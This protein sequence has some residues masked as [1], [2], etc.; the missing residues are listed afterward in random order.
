MSKPL[1]NNPG[2]NTPSVLNA[3][4]KDLNRT[5]LHG[6]RAKDDQGRYKPVAIL[7]GQ[8]EA[9]DRAT[10]KQPVSFNLDGKTLV[11]LR[12]HAAKVDA[13]WEGATEALKEGSGYFQL[14][15]DIL[16]K[17]LATQKTLSL[18]EP[19]NRTAED[20]LDLPDERSALRLPPAL[21]GEL[22]ASGDR[23]IS[24][25]QVK[26][27]D[28][29]VKK[30]R[31]RDLV[32]LLPA[33]WEPAMILRCATTPACAP[34]DK[35]P[36]LELRG[37]P[38]G[39][40]WFLDALELLPTDGLPGKDL[41]PDCALSLWLEEGTNGQL[42]RPKPERIGSWTLARRNLTRLARPG[43][44]TFMAAAED[45]AYPYWS[46]QSMPADTL[47]LLQM[48][49]ITNSGGY[50]L[51]MP[52]M[53]VALAKENMT[54]VILL[55]FGG[56]PESNPGSARRM[57]PSANAISYDN[58]SEQDGRK[59]NEPEVVRLEGNANLSLSCYGAGGC[60][61]FGFIRTLPDL[62]DGKDTLH[63]AAGFAA[64]I[65]MLE[66]GVND[67]SGR[68]IRCFVNKKEVEQCIPEAMTPLSP[69]GDLMSPLD[70][71]KVM[72]AAE[73]APPLNPVLNVNRFT[74][75]TLRA[76]GAKGPKAEMKYYFYRTNFR[77][78]S[79]DERGTLYRRLKGDN[80]LTVV[81]GFRD[82]FGN[83]IKRGSFHQEIALYYTDALIAPAEWP[84]IE[85][86]LTPL[87]PAGSRAKVCLSASYSAF[88]P[89]A[90]HEGDVDFL[91][92][93]ERLLNS[94]EDPFAQMLR[95][96]LSGPL[97]KLLC[98]TGDL[99]HGAAQEA[100]SRLALELNRILNEGLDD[101][102]LFKGDGP[103]VDD[104]TLRLKASATDGWSR[105]RLNRKHMEAGLGTAMRRI[106]STD[107]DQ[108][109]NQ[110]ERLR[111]IREQLIGTG[112]DDVEVRL[113]DASFSFSPLGKDLRTELIG[114][115]DEI[116]DAPQLPREASC[117]FHV[118]A[119]GGDSLS[120]SRFAPELEIKRNSKYLPT[121][122]SL[123]WTEDTD[124]N[125]RRRVRELISNAHSRV[126]LALSTVADATRKAPW[127][128]EFR[129]VASQFR[130]HLGVPWKAQVGILRNRLNEHELWFIPNGH[131]PSSPSA[132]VLITPKPLKN[133]LGNGNFPIPDF[134]KW[135]GG[136][137]DDAI[138]EDF[139]ISQQ[140]FTKIDYDVV[141]RRIM[142]SIEAALLPDRLTGPRKRHWGKV[143]AAKNAL[144]RHL[145]RPSHVVPVFQ[146]D[147]GRVDESNSTRMCRDLFLRDLR[148]FYRIDTLLQVPVTPPALEAGGLRNFHG[149]I[150]AEFAGSRRSSGSRP[151]IPSFSD[152]VLSYEDSATGSGSK[153]G[154]ITFSYDLPPGEE[155]RWRDWHVETLKAELT[156]VQ[157]GESSDGEFSRGQW[158]ELVD[159]KESPACTIDLMSK[160]PTR[161]MQIPAI[162]RRFPVEPI[163]K[164]AATM[165]L[166]AAI[167]ELDHS[168]L[169][170]WDWIVNLATE[171]DGENDQ[172]HFEIEYPPD[173][174]P[175]PPLPRK[176]EFL[177]NLLHCMLVLDAAADVLAGMASLLPDEHAKALLNAVALL[178][179]DMKSFLQR[180]NVSSRSSI[181]KDLFKLS[182]AVT[183]E[184]PG[185]G[186]KA[187]EH[188]FVETA[189]FGLV[190]PDESSSNFLPRP[191]EASDPLYR[192]LIVSSGTR[193][194]R[195][196]AIRLFPSRG[197][198][199]FRPSISIVRNADL[200]EQKL[201]NPSLIYVC[202][203]VVWKSDVEVRQVLLQVPVK[204]SPGS[205]LQDV[206]HD[207][208]EA[209][210]GNALTDPFAG[211]AL[212]L[213]LKHV[214]TLDDSTALNP[215]RLIAVDQIPRTTRELA[216]QIR[217]VYGRWLT[218]ASQDE[219]DPAAAENLIASIMNR[220]P[221]L[222]IGLQVCAASGVSSTDSNAASIGRVL[223]EIE[224]LEIPL[225]G[226][227][228]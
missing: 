4:A 200:V 172:I 84:G 118:D 218:S 122:L 31:R 168:L 94:A 37:I 177:Q 123:R 55:E 99:P 143:L 32:E 34:G 210:F 59:L 42:E 75:D 36:I 108:E 7:A 26:T 188:H 49:S 57:P 16:P 13:S 74:K 191:E 10:M 11:T 184:W 93:G 5:L 217:E 161:T 226:L 121:E 190:P 206:L 92:L 124:G 76:R 216:A 111:E 212:S 166:D 207:E 223:L 89:H 214:F 209:I 69:L 6:A 35:T 41:P 132:P 83:V 12:E 43:V 63:D 128:K 52:G 91:Q 95:E 179:G 145:A 100:A 147:A 170:K 114:F 44:E 148:N 163:L 51:A 153:P 159:F 180:E 21:L 70:R 151:T 112:D 62:V 85:F 79:L 127:E 175:P 135:K 187:K 149:R 104:A 176:A 86:H 134:S 81:A 103:Q 20:V 87:A 82:L 105:R 133:Q 197:A 141:G 29:P 23:R 157:F 65:Q 137:G 50:Y 119:T 183:T 28:D 193:A 46:D 88:D 3:V 204:T 219:W 102:P 98:K 142:N 164:S 68:P 9:A 17:W 189:Y 181:P 101:E 202:G 71:V 24:L 227:K 221:K 96:R 77:H 107:P 185:S 150:S 56:A 61:N 30:T 47:R 201:T 154:A 196:G 48:A 167:V 174:G 195:R 182:S 158:L 156:H 203:P 1:E 116:M 8:Q 126:P 194:D 27:V 160:V 152:F 224:S 110:L 131:L 25:C 178:L 106:A 169:A 162:L 109:A 144:A 54:L 58:P 130:R 120:L 208:L 53:P 73:S 45:P 146:D 222:S 165:P 117:E 90:F 39:D 211:L 19:G 60:F 72:S 225:H 215:F 33:T 18:P 228:F 139:E 113:V 155:T 199:R 129:A 198:A 138:P 2:P 78:A 97:R 140:S 173:S 136:P 192:E 15:P 38:Q 80:R 186:E 171:K 205:R 40:R 14:T 22:E 213:E 220:Q 66:F 115:L 64:G 125:I 67:Q